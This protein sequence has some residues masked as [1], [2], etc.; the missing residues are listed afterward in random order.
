MISW[1]TTQNGGPL[2]VINRDFTL[3]L[4]QICGFLFCFVFLGGLGTKKNMVCF[5]VLFLVSSYIIV[6][7]VLFGFIPILNE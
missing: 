1:W 3:F 2:L 4:F 7:S 6:V 5:Q